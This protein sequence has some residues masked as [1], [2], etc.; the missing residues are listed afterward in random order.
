MGRPK[1]VW[2]G[3]ASGHRPGWRRRLVMTARCPAHRDGHRQQRGPRRQRQ[4]QATG[5]VTA[6]RQATVATQITGTPGPRC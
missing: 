2:A 4:L 3:K 5:Y 6:K 1:V